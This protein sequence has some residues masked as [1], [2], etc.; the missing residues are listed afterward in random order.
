LLER[1][2][3]VGAGVA[4]LALGR[5]LR[6]RGIPAEI[7]ER[8]AAW[9]GRG[10]GLYLPANAVRALRDL[11]VGERIIAAGRVNRRRRFMTAEGRHL[12][13]VDVARFWGDVSPCIG[14]HRT[15]LHQALLDGMEDVPLQLATT[16]RTMQQSDEVEVTFHDGVVGRYGLVVGADGVRSSIRDLT[17][18]PAPPHRA[19]LASASWRFVVPNVIDVDCWTLWSGRRAI[20]LTVPI[21]AERIYVF[22]A[23]TVGEQVVEQPSHQ[24]FLDAFERFPAPVRRVVAEVAGRPDRLYYSPIDE[25]DQRPM[26]RGRVVLIGDAAHAMAPTMAQGAALAVE[27]ALVLAELLAMRTPSH[28]VV[29]AFERRRRPRIEWVRQHT[30]RQARL[31]NLPYPVRNLA[32]RLAGA[33]LWEKSFA[34][35]RDAY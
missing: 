26:G 9:D 7:V 1:V 29:D 12:F 3:I 21:D 14:V 28:E 24:R 13:D 18:G 32:A 2:L 22:A 8:H 25:I 5:A 23:F 27:D 19:S 10:T 15:A 20:L 31:L 34:P 33:R 4:G 17:F 6:Q 16:V 30:E 11:G 35:L